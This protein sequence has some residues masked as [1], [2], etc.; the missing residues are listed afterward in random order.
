MDGLERERLLLQRRV[1]GFLVIFLRP[2][3]GDAADVAQ[4]LGE[5]SPCGGSFGLGGHLG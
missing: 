1:L 2:S 4:F 3:A 5:G